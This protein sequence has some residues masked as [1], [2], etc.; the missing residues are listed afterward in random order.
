[1]ITDNKDIEMELFYIKSIL[2]QWD[3]GVFSIRDI[4][5]TGIMIAIN[6]VKISNI[7]ACIYQNIIITFFLMIFLLFLNFKWC[8][9]DKLIIEEIIIIIINNKSRTVDQSISNGY[10]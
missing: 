2:N 1:M 10:L 8:F 6:M 9:T 3:N 5:I 4:H 7:Y